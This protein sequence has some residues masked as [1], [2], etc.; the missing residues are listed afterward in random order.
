MVVEPSVEIKQA[1][2]FLL[3][4]WTQMDVKGWLVMIVLA[5]VI[6]LG[7]LFAAIAY[8]NGSSSVIA[9]F[10]Y[11]Y[12]AFSTFWGLVFFAEAPDGL[13]I[14]GMSMIAGAGL[15]AVRQ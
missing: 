13:T 12:L 8:Q 3:G 11:S 2:S 9:S 7:S 14:L 1:N 10:D 4:D 15:I 6:T 5:V